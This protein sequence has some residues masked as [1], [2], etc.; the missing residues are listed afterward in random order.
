MLKFPEDPIVISGIGMITSIGADRESVWR[1]LQAGESGV[2]WVRNFP[3]IPDDYLIAAQVKLPHDPSNRLKVIRLAE[4]AA[5]EAVA[6]AGIANVDKSRVGCMISANFGDDRW[7]DPPNLASPDSED[8]ATPGEIDRAREHQWWQQFLPNTTGSVLANRYGFLGPR[9]CHSTACASSLVSVMG[10]ARAILN[11]QCDVALAGGSEM[12]SKLTASGFKKM[13]ALA[14]D[15]D[16]KR[17]CRPFDK[18]RKGFVMGEGAGMLVLE[19]KS[20]ALKRGARIYAEIC[21]SHILAQAHHVTGLDAESE[22]LTHLLNITLE[23]GNLAPSDIGYINAHGTGTEQNDRAEVRGIRRS[24]GKAADD[25]IMSSSKSMYGHL[26][27]AA[28]SVELATMVLAMRDGFAPPTVNLNDPDPDCDV[29]CLAAVGRH[30]QFEFGMKISVAFGGHL[31]AL[32]LRR[33]ND[34]ASGYA[35]PTVRRAA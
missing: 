1:A 13:R 11:G 4:I 34:A 23:K 5:D 32:A 3:G 29:D 19:R 21:S 25:L 8:S 26:I 18:T 27:T 31:V 2:D 12:I 14:E 22:V 30:R 6:D 7:Y 15:D 35:Y 17:A 24:F 28:G 9:I 16:P 20:H 10:A 33:W